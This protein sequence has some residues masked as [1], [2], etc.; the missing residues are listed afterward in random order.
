MSLQSN[1]SNQ[2]IYASNYTEIPNVVFDY[3]MNHLTHAEFKVLCAICRKTFGWHKFQDYISIKQMVALTGVSKR[4]VQESILILQKHGL[5][6]IV[7]SKTLDGDDAPNLYRIMV[8]EANIESS[9][10]IAPPHA[11]SDINKGGGRAASAL[12]VGQPVHP[13][14]KDLQKKEQQQQE[15]VVVSSEDILQKNIE[16]SQAMALHMIDFAKN[17]GQQWKITENTFL[18]M[19]KQGGCLYVTDQLNYMIKQ[20]EKAE[21]DNEN[22]YQKRKTPSIGNPTTFLCMACASNYA[23]SS[24]RKS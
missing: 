10:A 6:E 20:Q 1:T 19:I 18:Q 7:R 9:A 2:K 15:V 8:N 16:T 13:Q 4:S 3:W 11:E 17:R 14:K 22:S 5:I 23:N 24:R 21:R 12:G